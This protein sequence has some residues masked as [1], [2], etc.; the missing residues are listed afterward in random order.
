MNRLLALAA[1]VALN[2]CTCKFPWDLVDA[3]A[4]PE[5]DAIVG[6][7]EPITEGGTTSFGG[8]DF[9]TTLDADGGRSVVVSTGGSNVL[10]LIYS[11]DTVA[12]VGDFNQDGVNDYQ[13]TS[14]VSGDQVLNQTLNDEDRDGVWDEKEE[15]IFDLT[16][17]F[18]LSLSESFSV[19]DGGVDGGAAGWQLQSS[20]TGRAVA[21]QNAGGTNPNDCDGYA[22]LPEHFEQ[23]AFLPVPNTRIHI[24]TNG[25]A[26]SCTRE[27]AFAILSG[28]KEALKDIAPCLASANPKLGAQLK[29]ALSSAPLYVGCGNTCPAVASTELP[30]GEFSNFKTWYFGWRAVTF[31]A[32]RMNVNPGYLSHSTT[33]LAEFLMHELLHYS[34]SNHIP[35]PEGDPPGRDR[36]YGCGRYCTRCKSASSE[37]GIDS[38]DS[39]AWDCALCS[40]SDHRAA[41]GVKFYN[42]AASAAACCTDQ[43]PGSCTACKQMHPFY[44]D[45]KTRPPASAPAFCCAAGTSTCADPMVAPDCVDG[46][47]DI[48]NHYNR[49]AQY[50]TG[51]CTEGGLAK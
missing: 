12:A 27:Q 15:Q 7:M 1:L 11:G 31:Q 40:D 16:N 4:D 14:T 9:E 5:F 37:G 33:Y 43:N 26:G 46:E 29:I 3:G 6:P 21:N 39:Y 45:G 2:G 10:S 47:T 34:G 8:L 24:V 49:C 17:G 44:C 22:G 25:E 30:A 23:G 20:Y 41:C 13:Y 35:V 48:K 38:A 42:V 51:W 28:F 18:P 32:Q 36:V 19:V 50:P